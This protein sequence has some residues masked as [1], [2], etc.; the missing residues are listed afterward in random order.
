[1]A[2]LRAAIAAKDA[3]MERQMREDAE[4][5]ARQVDAAQREV[6]AT[7][8][9]NQEKTERIKL[10]REAADKEKYCCLADHLHLLPLISADSRRVRRRA[11]QLSL[12]MSW[13]LVCCRFRRIAKEA[14]EK[15]E[16][17]NERQ[18]EKERRAEAAFKEAKNAQYEATLAAHVR[19]QRM[20]ELRL[21][22]EKAVQLESRHLVSA[23]EELSGEWE[24]AAQ[25]NARRI[26]ADYQTLK[27]QYVEGSLTPLAISPSVSPGRKSS[28]ERRSPGRSPISSPGRS[29]GRS[30][31]NYTRIPPEELFVDY[32]RAAHAYPE[33]GR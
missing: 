13:H 21:E 24:K 11:G 12:C 26:F 2:D 32:Q 20:E 9:K 17:D 25:A 3:A 4:H 1:M 23:W 27:E 8:K 19:R 18:R 6:A 22:N 33:L 28:P 15:I 14:R 29:P 16:Q 30:M 7:F 31:D 5:R 10:E